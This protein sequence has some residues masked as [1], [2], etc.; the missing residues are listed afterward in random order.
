MNHF[1]HQHQPS[2]VS[3]SPSSCIRTFQ[4]IRTSSSTWTTPLVELRSFCDTRAPLRKTWPAGG[5][6]GWEIDTKGRGDE[7]GK[8]GRGEGGR[9]RGS[10]EM[11]RF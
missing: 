8:G 10:R 4:G 1:N 3:P 9:C 11:G 2:T 5:I 6:G 7:E